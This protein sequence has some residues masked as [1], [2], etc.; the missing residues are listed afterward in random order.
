MW[1]VQ[2]GLGTHATEKITYR[3]LMG[4]SW[5]E[6]GGHANADCGWTYSLDANWKI[7]RQWQLSVLGKSYYQPSERTR[8]QAIKVYSLS[9]GVS[10]LTLG[11]KMTLTANIA[12][13]Y[14]DT[15][16]NDRYI[17]YG[18]DFDETILS[19]RLGA[20]YIINRWVSVFANFTWEE[21]W[22]DRRAYDYNRFRGTI[23]MRFHY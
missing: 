17:A 3:A 18:N 1:T 20:S 14:E 21:E 12:W 2:A 22:C 8:G 5:L 15:C 13:R 19:V 11:D 9:S 4:A 10:Y 16:Y 23:G 7:T 6:Y